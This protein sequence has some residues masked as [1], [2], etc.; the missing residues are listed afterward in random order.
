MSD[1]NKTSDEQD[2]AGA[3]L[4]DFYALAQQ[5]QRVVRAFWERQA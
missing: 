5:S 2:T 4:G 1:Q 3:T